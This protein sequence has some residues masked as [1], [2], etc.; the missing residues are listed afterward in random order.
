[1][2][3]SQVLGLE[4]Y[5]TH[6]ATNSALIHATPS[7]PLTSTPLRLARR[8]SP[9]TLYNLTSQAVRTLNSYCFKIVPD[10]SNAV[11]CFLIV[12]VLY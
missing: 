12:C 1:M 2:K 4:V 5:V 7:L 10:L 3:G 11:E 9:P 6:R 8:R